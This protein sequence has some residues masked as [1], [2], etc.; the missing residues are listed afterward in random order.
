MKGFF[1]KHF[2]ALKNTQRHWLRKTIGVL[3]VIG[4]VLGFLPVL[5]YWMLPLGLV[6]LAVDFPLIRRFNRRVAVWWERKRRRHGGKFQAAVD[7]LTT[8]R[9][10][11]R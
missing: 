10:D 1:K 4:G 3:L 7:S 8:R 2:H 6:L 11:R 9:K 5:G